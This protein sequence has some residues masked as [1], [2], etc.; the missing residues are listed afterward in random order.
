MREEQEKARPDLRSR[1]ITSAEWRD[2][3]DGALPVLART[4]FVTG[5]VDAATLHIA[6]LG[7]F[8][9][10]ING[11][12]VSADLLE[13]GYTDYAQRAE[14]CSYAV[15]DLLV[16]GDNVISIELGPGNYR[17]QNADGRWTKVITDYGD[18]A[19]CAVLEWDASA[20]PG[21]IE[22]DESWSAALGPVR[23]ANW[24]GGE[25]YDATHDL[26]LHPAAIASWQRA[27][28]AAVPAGMILSAKTTPPLRIV[29]ELSAV[30]ITEPS[31]DVYV[32]DF[33]VNFAGWTE[34]ELPAHTAVRLRPAELL[35]ADGNINEVT[36]GWGP[37]F[38]TV[39]TAGQPMSWHPQF[40]YNGLRYLEIIGLDAAPVVDSVRGLVIAASAAPAGEFEC[41]DERL[42][43]L[44]RIIRRAITSNMFSMFTDC[45]QREKLGY[46]EQLHLVY[47]ILQWNY[48]V[49]SLLT[50]TLRL[51][52]ESQ[53]PSGHIALYVP[54]WDPFPDPWRGDV[55]FG[56]V[57]V[58]LPWQLWRA[59]GDQSILA[60]NYA[61]ATR[62]IE[63]LLDSRADGLV[64]YGLGDWNGRDVRYAPF[65]ATAT[66]ARALGVLA[67]IAGQLEAPADAYRWFGLRSELLATLRDRFVHSD[68]EV[69]DGSVAELV[70]A[71]QSGVVPRSDAG[72]AV[73]RLEARIID[74]DYALDVGEV[75]MAALVSVLSA[76]DR[77]DTLYR[78]TRQ[79]E[80][81]GYGYMLRHGATSLTETWDGPTWGFSQNHFMNGAID[82]WFFSHVAG[83]QQHPHDT[84]YRRVIVRPRPCGDLTSARAVYRTRT[85]VLSSSWRLEGSRFLLDVV[86]SPGVSGDVVLPDG[87][88][89]FVEHGTHSFACDRVEVLA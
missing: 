88:T 23:S 61:T 58:F 48:D 60:E 79:D 18:L 63:Y 34:I 75:A 37:V 74:G 22:T 24:V 59:Y 52:R 11:R 39:R 89:H 25:D 42:T 82:D 20:G 6:G 1:W 85:G 7:I 33:G 12:R 68:G 30:A 65:V 2:D 21:Q 10:R 47:P 45:P 27:V 81:P 71:I 28:A 4:F 78:V 5:P 46:L 64:V 84:G 8:T 77:H 53:E 9:A 49:E 50:N 69:G 32:V 80:R 62:Y 36:E 55:N 54:E 31:P 29:E 86:L 87:S 43:Q 72:A 67:W 14:F 35:H 56:L 26:D 38:H 73:D 57:V 40:M 44:H 51:V 15:A 66:L 83:I 70:V 76:H 16:C 41:S 3:P 17:S 13:P 19:S